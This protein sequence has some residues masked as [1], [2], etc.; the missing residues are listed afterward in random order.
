ME[1]LSKAFL[2]TQFFPFLITFQAKNLEVAQSD[3][4]VT[5]QCRDRLREKMETWS[6]LQRIVEDMKNCGPLAPWK[7][8]MDTLSLYH[9]PSLQ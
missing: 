7:W 2:I 5:L 4:G 3:G 8:G 9:L 6:I 1:G